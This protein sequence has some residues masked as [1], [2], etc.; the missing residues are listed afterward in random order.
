MIFSC[1]GVISSRI[2]LENESRVMKALKMFTQIAWSGELASQIKSG[3][4]F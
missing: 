1:R 3:N 2:G 4:C